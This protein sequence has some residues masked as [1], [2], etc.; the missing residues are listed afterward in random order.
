MLYLWCMMFFLFYKN[1]SE[2]VTLTI[3]D[4]DDT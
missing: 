4:V 3:S 1:H 2:Y